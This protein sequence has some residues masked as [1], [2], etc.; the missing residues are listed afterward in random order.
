MQITSELLV[1]CQPKLAG[2]QQQDFEYLTTTLI[3]AI[4]RLRFTAAGR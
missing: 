4:Y 1:P 2:V 3:L